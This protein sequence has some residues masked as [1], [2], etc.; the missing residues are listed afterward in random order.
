MAFLLKQNF[1]CRLQL[2][3][4]LSNIQTGGYTLP[5]RICQCG[6]R[7]SGGDVCFLQFAAS[8]HKRCLAVIMGALYAS[9]CALCPETCACVLNPMSRPGPVPYT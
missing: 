3:P 4:P 1:F 5:G 9:P 2:F 7:D 8:P 6:G